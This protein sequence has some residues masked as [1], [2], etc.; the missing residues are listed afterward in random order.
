MAS[1]HGDVHL[2][3]WHWYGL[4]WRGLSVWCVCPIVPWE[5]RVLLGICEV[6]VSGASTDLHSQVCSRLPTHV[7]H[8][9]WDPSFDVGPRKRPEDCPALPIWGG[10]LGSYCVV[11]CRAGSHVKCRSSQHHRPINWLSQTALPSCLSLL[12]P[13]NKVILT[14]FNPSLFA[15]SPLSPVEW[16]VN[17]SNRKGAVC[18]LFLT[19]EWL[20]KRPFL[21][22]SLQPTLGVETLILSPYWALICAEDQLLAPSS[23]DSVNNAS[24]VASAVGTGGE[25]LGATACGLLG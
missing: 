14:C 23:W 12:S 7:S 8:L 13:A 10:C 22:H 15:D 16:L 9:E 4:E 11:L 6:F 3:S 21:A 17:H 19:M 20:S 5:L 18:P 1:S 24:S 2:P 25:A